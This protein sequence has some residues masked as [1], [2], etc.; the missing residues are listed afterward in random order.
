MGMMQDAT[1]DESTKDQSPLESTASLLRRV[2]AGDE[3]ARNEILRRYRD[4]LRR[5]AHGRRHPGGLEDTEDLVQETLKRALGILKTFVPKREGAFLAYL[6]TILKNL[7]LDEDRRQKRRPRPVEM[8]EEVVKEIPSQLD[9][10]IG[11]E[12]FDKYEKA[13]KRFAPRTR[14][15]L[16]LRLELGFTYRQI[17]EALNNRPETDMHIPSESA[18]RVLI[19]RAIVKLAKLMGDSETS[20]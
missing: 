1:A 13:L 8:P 4:I 19:Q 2:R 18:V 5:W 16:I 20:P 11:R 14:E 6:R 7:I 3:S 17:A 15:A 12:V 10:L 9:E